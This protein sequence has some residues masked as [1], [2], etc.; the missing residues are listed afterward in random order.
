MP[1][2]IAIIGAGPAGMTAALFAAKAGVQVT[3]LESNAVVGRKLLVTGSGRANLTNQGVSAERYTCADPAWMETLLTKFGHEDLLS[4]LNEIGVLTTSTADGWFYPISDSAQTVAAAFD[5]ALQRAGV[6]V[7]LGCHIS[8]IRKS[9]A[10]FTLKIDGQ[11]DLTCKKIILAAGGKAYPTLGSKGELFPSLKA[12]G[13]TVLPLVP[14]LAPVT[15]E[16]KAFRPLQGVRVDAH[17]S[18][19]YSGVQHV[20]FLVPP[21]EARGAV[22]QPV[23]ETTGNIIFTEWGIN[24]PGVMDLSHHIARHPETHFELRLNFLPDHEDAVRALTHQHRHEKIPLMVIP[25]GALPP[26]LSA[27]LIARAGLPKDALLSKTSDAQLDALMALITSLPLKVTGVRGFEYCQ[28]SAGGV[29]IGEV[30]PT[31]MQSRVVPGLYL[32]GETLDVVG[33]CGGYNLQFAFSSGAVAGSAIR[34]EKPVS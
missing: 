21:S 27:F 9:P 3:L 8:S 16:M 32:V 1:N 4:F 15:C 7:R 31:T 30:D 24:G 13:H 11:P 18:L 29:P 34:E 12:L 22:P 17:V 25:G 19:I 33:P 2:S 28:V 14:A 6:N 23:A 20:A 10:G 26:K 5:S